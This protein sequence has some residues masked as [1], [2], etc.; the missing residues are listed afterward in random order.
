MRH[1][2]FVA[3]RTEALSYLP[4][5]ARDLLVDVE[6]VGALRTLGVVPLHAL[7]CIRLAPLDLLA[8]HLRV[9]RK[10]QA[11]RRAKGDKSQ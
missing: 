6:Q 5:L 10:N 9:T 3:W 8:N 1:D 4:A 7:E 2:M 11:S